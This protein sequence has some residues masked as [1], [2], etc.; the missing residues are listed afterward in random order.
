MPASRVADRPERLRCGGL[1][2]DLGAERAV[3]GREQPAGGGA[4][5]HARPLEDDAPADTTR[6]LKN[7]G[8]GPFGP[9]PAVRTSGPGQKTSVTPSRMTR[10]SWYAPK[11]GLAAEKALRS[12]IAPMAR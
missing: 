8:A 3:G 7:E 6:G 11:F 10:K 5:L 2:R 4:R 1:E 9:T 12:A